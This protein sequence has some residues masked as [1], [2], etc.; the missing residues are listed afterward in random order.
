M[1]GS[2]SHR[3]AYFLSCVSSL[4]SFPLLPEAYRKN[5]GA[6]VEMIL[7][8]DVSYLTNT[9]QASVGHSTNQWYQVL[10]NL[11]KL[12]PWHLNL[13]RSQSL[14]AENERSGKDQFLGDPDW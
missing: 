14:L 2:H 12:D 11:E 4:V 1:T 3:I 6:H 9:I 10:R 13:T 7:R 5:N 8:L